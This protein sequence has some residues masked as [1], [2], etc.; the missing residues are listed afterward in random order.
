MIKEY[1]LKFLRFVYG[2]VDFVVISTIFILTNIPVMIWEVYLVGVGWSDEWKV[3]IASIIVDIIFAK[4]YL[5]LRGFLEK[6]ISINNELVNLYVTD[7]LAILITY[8]V[9]KSLKFFVFSKIGWISMDGLNIAILSI[10]VFAVFLGRLTGLIIDRSHIFIQ[11]KITT[12][13]EKRIWIWLTPFWGEHFFF[14]K[15]LFIQIQFFSNIFRN[16]FS[17]SICLVKL[18]HSIFQCINT[19]ITHQDTRIFIY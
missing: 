12:F 13:L 7:T 4:P 16:Q 1:H 2:N 11:R 14:W 6:E 19:F 8:A 15:K 5:Y 18:F 9:L 17:I 3:R 10:V